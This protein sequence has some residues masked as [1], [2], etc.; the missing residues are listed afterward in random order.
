VLALV[1]AIA[2]LQ[3]SAPCQDP[4]LALRCPDLVMAA[5]SHL[6]AER[7]ESGRLLLRMQNRIVNIG[8]GPVEFFGE[9]T[10]PREMSARQV[11]ADG[12][13]V[14]R[15]Y[16]TGAEVYY[17]SVPARGGDYWKFDDAARFE[18]WSQFPDGRR[19]QLVRIGPKLRYCL[20]DLERISDA[21]ELPGTPPR[22]VFGACSQSRTKQTVTLGTSVGWADVYPA[23]YPGNFIEVTGLPAGCYVAIHRVDPERHV[24]ELNEANNTSAKVVRLP[25]RPGRQGCPLYV[26]S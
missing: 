3:V 11:I 25:F 4:A 20:R 1:A 2:A 17:T 5:P 14:R 16:Q 15:R 7:T 12:F 23:A 6:R 26:P 24:L 19:A 8:A 9:R 22:R 10:G 18:L 21:V 13:G